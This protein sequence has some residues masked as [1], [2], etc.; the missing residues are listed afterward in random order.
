MV[1][2]STGK[3]FGKSEGNAIWLDPNKS[4]PFSVY[5]YF[6]NTTDE[7]VE[8][9]LKLFTLLDFDTI[10]GISKKHAADPAARYGQQELAKYVV[11]TIFGTQAAQQAISITQLLFVTEDKLSSIKTLDAAT[12]DALVAATG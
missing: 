8:R 12:I 3:K 10:A 1:L 2:D 9:Y 4:T 6:M 11:T 5:Q 7:D